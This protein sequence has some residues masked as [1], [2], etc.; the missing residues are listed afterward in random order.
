MAEPSSYSAAQ[1]AVLL[2]N[3]TKI[4][5]LRLSDPD[6][7]MSAFKAHLADNR[8]ANVYPCTLSSNTYRKMM[9]LCCPVPISMR[10]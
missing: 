10:L 9:P 6:F 3:L 5:A 7:R 2:D 8:Y 4:D 1:V